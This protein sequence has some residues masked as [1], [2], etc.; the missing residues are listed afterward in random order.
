MSNDAE[1]L[2]CF[3]LISQNAYHDFKPLNKVKIGGI[4]MSRPGS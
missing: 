3:F 4:A 2:Q 1:W